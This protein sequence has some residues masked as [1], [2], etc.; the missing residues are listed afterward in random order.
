MK[1]ANAKM[2]TME[3]PGNDT[4][5]DDSAERQCKGETT[6]INFPETERLEE[7]PKG[8]PD[9]IQEGGESNKVENGFCD[10]N[11][12]D[13]AI[14]SAEDGSEQHTILCESAKT[15]NHQNSPADNQLVGNITNEQNGTSHRQSEPEI[16]KNLAV[17]DGNSETLKHSNG[18]TL[19]EPVHY[20]ENGL[21]NS[22]ELGALKFSD[23]GSSCN[24][25]NGLAAEGM[26]TFDDTEPNRSEHAED[27]DVSLVETSCPAKSG[28]VCLY[29]CCS[30]CLHAVHKIIQKFLARKL[31][32]NK[33]KLTT[34]DVH[35]AVASL[36]VDLLSVIRKIDVTEE[37]SNS[38]KESSDRNPER[39]DDIPELHSCQCKSSGDSSVVPTECG[40]H[41]V[42]ESVNVKASHSPGSQLGL[43]PKFI[44]RD[45]ILVPVDT[46]EDVSFHCKYKTLCLCSLVKSVAM[47]KQ[48]FG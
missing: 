21:C 42:F 40:C 17:T 10:L 18:Y 47:M 3:F 5:V 14:L 22:G 43:D 11:P 6:D 28:I 46:T 32:L 31:A 24:Q 23:P 27:I 44:F 4:C 29:R 39:Y 33:S 20:S 26:V 45:G 15:D 8:F 1:V 36:S 38:F 19:T 12:E 35:D 2:K 41:S 9:K 30:V 48:S 37:I 16:T 13:G 7:S 25:S 34:E